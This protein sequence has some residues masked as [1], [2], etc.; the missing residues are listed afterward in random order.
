M[1][2]PRCSGLSDSNVK[3][4]ENCVTWII[5]IPDKSCEFADE[6]GRPSRSHF[7]WTGESPF[8][9]LQRTLYR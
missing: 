1:L 8:V 2:L 3:V 6:M 4:D 5:L 7:I 9:T